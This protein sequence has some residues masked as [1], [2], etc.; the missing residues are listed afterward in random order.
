MENYSSKERLHFPQHGNNFL[1][2]L[3]KVQGE[4]NTKMKKKRKFAV[5]LL[6]KYNEPEKFPCIFVFHFMSQRQLVSI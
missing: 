6:V 5:L 2:F 1:F 4:K 3:D